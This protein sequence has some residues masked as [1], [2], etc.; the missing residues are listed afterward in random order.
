MDLHIWEQFWVCNRV[1]HTS[2]S[3]SH[4]ETPP[5]MPGR[6]VDGDFSDGDYSM[7]VFTYD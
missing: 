3:G 4:S 2:C 5:G 6:L 1:G 7:N